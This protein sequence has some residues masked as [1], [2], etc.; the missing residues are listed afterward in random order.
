MLRIKGKRGYI[1]YVQCKILFSSK[2]TVTI[3]IKLFLKL[4]IIYCRFTIFRRCLDA[5]M[6]DNTRQG[7]SLQTKKE[8]KEAD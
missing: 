2:S 5:E 4:S 6:N 3:W 7:V 8:E 1:I